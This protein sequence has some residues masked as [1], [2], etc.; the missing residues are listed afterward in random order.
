MPKKKAII[1][2][3]IQKVTLKECRVELFRISKDEIKLFTN[4]IIFSKSFHVRIH[5]QTMEIG[6]KKC[7]STNRS[8]HIKI[9]KHQLDLIAEPS[10]TSITVEKTKENEVVAVDSKLPEAIVSGTSPNAPIESI[11]NKDTL[12]GKALTEFINA[13]WRESKKEYR[14]T[15]NIIQIG[16]LVMAKMSTYSPWGS[17]VLSF[18]KNKQRATVCFFGE[19]L[20][21]SVNVAEI[22]PFNR[23]TDVIRL[24][25]LRKFSDFH[26]SI[27]EIER[28]LGVPDH[29]SLLNEQKQIANS[30]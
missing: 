20:R 22:V 26:K 21:G 9:K 27:I 5:G 24:L 16:D 10:A 7:V 4:S 2:Q 17:R 12:I 14:K 28:I 1:R 18:T 23:C 29:L 8:F 6:E 3:S 13:K 11:Q 15:R 19:G 25:L 30:K